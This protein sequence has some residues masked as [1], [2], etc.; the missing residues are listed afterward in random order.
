MALGAKD[1]LLDENDDLQTA[2]GDFM[3]GD[4]DEQNADLIIRSVQGNWLNSLLT[5]FNIW[6]WLKANLD[7]YRFE[8]ELKIQLEEMEGYVIEELELTQTIDVGLTID[9]LTLK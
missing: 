9:K 4:S 7:K 8:R 3:I 5:G 2:N 6:R 1:I